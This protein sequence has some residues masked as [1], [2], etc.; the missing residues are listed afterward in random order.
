M[1]ALASSL[2][3]AYPVESDNMASKSRHLTPLWPPTASDVVVETSCVLAVLKGKFSI[4]EIRATRQQI[5]V[6][7]HMHIQ[8]FQSGTEELYT[9]LGRRAGHEQNRIDIGTTQQYAL[10]SRSQMCVCA[11]AVRNLCQTNDRRGR[12]YQRLPK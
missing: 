9:I 11:R 1:D 10:T 4:I 5:S 2:D 7:S 3:T 8:S 12:R 6:I